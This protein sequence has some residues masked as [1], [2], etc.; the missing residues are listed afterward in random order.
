M[1]S[2][3]G[4]D[5]GSSGDLPRYQSR[6]EYIRTLYRD[7]LE[8]LAGAPSV[9][10]S[11]PSREPTGWNKVDRTVDRII[12]G[13]AK[14]AAEEEYQAVGLLC[15]ECLISLAQAVF[16]PMK[17]IPA[18]GTQASDTDAYRMLEAYFSAEFPGPE[19][20]ALRRHAKASLSLANSL[21]HKRTAK[22]KDTALCS[23]ATRTVVNIVAIASERR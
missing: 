19:N 20:E 8:E 23:E 3:H 14:A 4:T 7:L 18:D 15:R 6:R 13:L 11:E 21:Q 2:G 22:Y 12:T 10:I 16:D 5:V 1:T 17:H 9:S